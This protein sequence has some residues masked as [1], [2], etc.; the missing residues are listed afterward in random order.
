GSSEATAA[1]TTSASFRAGM[2]TAIRTGSLAKAGAASGRMRQNPPRPSRRYTQISR[3]RTPAAMSIQNIVRG[4]NP[5]VPRASCWACSLIQEVFCPHLA[6]LL[7]VVL[8]ALGN[9]AR[10]VAVGQCVKYLLVGER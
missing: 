6:E 3:L 2:I 8:P 9:S 10:I 7:Q 5:R 1:P 4:T